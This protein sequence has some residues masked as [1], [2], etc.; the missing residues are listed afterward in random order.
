MSFELLLNNIKYEPSIIYED[1]FTDKIMPYISNI[2]EEKYLSDENILVFLF[3]YKVYYHYTDM[4]EKYGVTEKKLIKYSKK[5][6]HNFS[7]KYLKAFKWYFNKWRTNEG[8]YLLDILMGMH[9]EL[10][11]NLNDLN[12]DKQNIVKKTIN[13]LE[14]RIK[15]LECDINM[16]K[17]VSSEL[18]S[19]N[20]CEKDGLPIN[21]YVEKHYWKI[22]LKQFKHIESYKLIL[23]EYLQYII[24]KIEEKE[25]NTSGIKLYLETITKNTCDDICMVTCSEFYLMIDDLILYNCALTKNSY[26]NELK[27]FINNYLHQDVKIAIHDLFINILK[28]YFEN[29]L[30][31]NKRTRSYSF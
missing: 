13:D 17:Y 29:F 10:I 23:I 18:S 16:N 6:V 15:N 22:K 28:N 5:I 31:K 30:N 25:L 24:N 12:L 14:E 27:K 8:K 4:F 7:I 9:L 21:L 26:N 1:T 11:Y 3:A 2:I 19:R 20:S